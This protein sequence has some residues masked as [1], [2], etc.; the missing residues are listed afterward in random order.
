MLELS[1]QLPSGPDKD[2]YRDAAVFDDSGEAILQ[3]GAVHY[4]AGKNI[5]VPIIYGDFFFLE[6]LVKL[7]GGRGVF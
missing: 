3:G 1:D 4:P 5:N 2:F 7:N 6:A